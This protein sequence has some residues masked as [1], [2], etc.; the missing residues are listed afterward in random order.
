MNRG[1]FRISPE[2]RIL[3]AW[4]AII[5][6]AAEIPAIAATT[7]AIASKAPVATAA[8]ILA[9]FGFVDLESTAGHFLAIELFDG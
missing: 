7:T 8:T 3:P 1:R 4:L 2:E 5:T 9:R 6:T